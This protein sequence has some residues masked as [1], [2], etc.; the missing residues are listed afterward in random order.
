MLLVET[1]EHSY[2]GMIKLNDLSDVHLNFNF[3]FVRWFIIMAT[4]EYPALCCSYTEL[5]N[6]LQYYARYHWSVDVLRCKKRL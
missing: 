5:L 3:I 4:V 6:P 2:L 1:K